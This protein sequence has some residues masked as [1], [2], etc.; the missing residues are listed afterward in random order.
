MCNRLYAQIT[1]WCVLQFLDLGTNEWGDRE[2]CLLSLQ[3][4]LCWVETLVFLSRMTPS[5]LMV[6]TYSTVGQWPI[7]SNY[8]HF[9]TRDV[10]AIFIFV[11]IVNHILCDLLF[12]KMHF[13]VQKVKSNLFKCF[14]AFWSI[15]QLSSPMCDWKWSPFGEKR[16]EKGMTLWGRKIHSFPMHMCILH[17]FSNID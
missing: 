7:H 12:V 5:S 9:G 3:C 10:I 1:G 6:S 11:W 8:Y 2:L 17:A 16:K 14:S 15:Y 4:N 13:N